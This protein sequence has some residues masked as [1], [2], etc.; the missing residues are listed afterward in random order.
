MSSRSFGEGLL[1]SLWGIGS[2]SALDHEGMKARAGSD[3]DGARF[4]FYIVIR[5][6]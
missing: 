3:A 5:Y 1:K 6:I 2:V 4:V